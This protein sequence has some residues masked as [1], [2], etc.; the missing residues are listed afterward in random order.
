MRFTVMLISVSALVG[1]QKPSN[2]FDSN[3]TKESSLR[4]LAAS[5]QRV[6]SEANAAARR[7]SM[8]GIAVGIDEHTCAADDC[9]QIVTL[10]DKLLD[11]K[12]GVI[13]YW[14]AMSLG[15]LG[16]ASKEVVPHLR[17]RLKD[18]ESDYAEKSPASGIRFA[19]DRIAE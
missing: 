13:V 8:E 10:L 1:C 5:L 14:A 9:R 7:Q 18:Y 2:T 17:T 4:D 12:D 3:L 16:K 19:L 6:A 15:R 11:D